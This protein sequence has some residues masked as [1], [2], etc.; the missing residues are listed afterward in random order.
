LKPESGAFL[1]TVQVS[2]SSDVESNTVYY[3]LDGTEPTEQSSKYTGPFNISQSARIRAIA[4]DSRGVKSFIREANLVKATY[5]IRFANPPSTKYP[6][7]NQIILLD[8]RKSDPDFANGDWLGWEGTDMVVE[9]DLG[10]PKNFKGL[11]ADFLNATGS[12]IFLPTSV[13]F[14]YSDNGRSWQSA[15]TAIN[16][17]AWDKN[18]KAREEFGVDKTF[19][20][21]Y[22]RVKAISPKTCPAGHA[23]VG[24]PCWMF[25]D[26]INLGGL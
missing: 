25:A 9:I 16:P 1:D 10:E 15:G 17:T 11:K 22:I 20:A 14:D 2:I 13:Q 4:T 5:S 23:G 6:P 26:E 18:T 21:R 7:K 8:G 12:W 19:R 24:N 3:T